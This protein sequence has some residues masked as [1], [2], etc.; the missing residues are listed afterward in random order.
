MFSRLRWIRN[1]KLANFRQICKKLSGL[2][3]SLALFRREEAPLLLTPSVH[4]MDGLMVPTMK[5]CEICLHRKLVTSKSRLG[6]GINFVSIFTSKLKETVLPEYR[7]SGPSVRATVRA[8]VKD[9]FRA[10][11]RA[12]VRAAVRAFSQG[13]SQGRS[14]VLGHGYANQHNFL[15]LAYAFILKTS[16]D[17]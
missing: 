7:Q 14:H 9:A 2:N 8:A 17:V 6:F 5:F 1:H 10:K 11:V 12:A 13:R 16:R 15:L 3:I 4:P